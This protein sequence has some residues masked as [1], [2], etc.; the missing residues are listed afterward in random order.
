MALPTARATLH[1]PSHRSLISKVASNP[2]LPRP[3]KRLMNLIDSCFNA[4]TDAFSE[5][6]TKEWSLA[7]LRSP[8]RFL[9]FPSHPERV[10][11]V[12]L[13]INRLEG[14]GSEAVGTG[15]SENVE[16]GLVL[17]SIGYKS[18][19]MEGIPFDPKRGCVENVQGRIVNKVAESVVSSFILFPGLRFLFPFSVF[20]YFAPHRSRLNKSNGF[21]ACTLPDG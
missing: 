21:R 14:D 5:I 16:C 18:I 7:F 4:E 19:A 20:P 17:R 6:K 11:S 15:V 8:I 13:E 9:S 12:E 2:D 10:G 3:S 1:D